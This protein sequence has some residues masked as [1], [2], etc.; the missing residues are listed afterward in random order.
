MQ[1]ANSTFLLV[2]KCNLLVG[3][4]VITCRKIIC[5]NLS[6]K[7]GGR[8]NQGCTVRSYE[9]SLRQ[10]GTLERNWW[11]DFDATITQGAEKL[12]KEKE[13]SLK[14]REGRK[15]CRLAMPVIWSR[16]MLFGKHHGRVAQSLDSAIHWIAT[17]FK[18]V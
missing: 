2:R 1:L 15:L 10:E 12:K 17:I 14:E 5:I 18:L 3:I 7:P 4:M 13:W 11:D 16:I 9:V 8:L 6:K